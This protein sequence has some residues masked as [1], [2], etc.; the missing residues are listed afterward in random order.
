VPQLRPAPFLAVL[1]VAGLAL[2]GCGDASTS[3]T[4]DPL[5]AVSVSGGDAKKAPAITVKPVPLVA[6]TTQSKVLTEGKGEPVTATDIVSINVAIVNGKDGKTVNETWSSGA[7]V[8]IDLGAPTLFPALKTQLP[9]KKLGSRLLITSPPKDAF[10][11]QGN[12]SLGIG[13]TDSVAFVVDLLS[14][15]KPLAEAEGTA[16]APKAG[17]PT[18]TM[19]GGKPAT[20][21]IPKGAKAP[22]T[23]VTQPLITGKGAKVESGQTVR[24]TYTGALWKDGSVFDSSANSPQKYFEF[25]VGQGRVITGWDKSIVG[26][27]VGSRLL[28]VIPPAEGYG[29]AGSPPKISGTDTLVFVVDILAA[30]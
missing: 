28:L 30:Y 29:T 14:A 13:G 8:G 4:Q 17:L 3:T 25:P 22:T 21:A 6:N 12:T 26:Q 1:A 16:V 15:T 2:T 19:A 24:V 20:I 11:E 10:G 9:G 23:L 5:A 18:V 7:P 27:P